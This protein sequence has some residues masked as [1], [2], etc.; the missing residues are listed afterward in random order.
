[1]SSIQLPGTNLI[2]G[3]NVGA[4]GS[5][6]AAAA[7][8]EAFGQVGHAIQAFGEKGAGMLIQAKQS[9][10]R[11]RANDMQ[12]ELSQLMAEQDHEMIENPDATQW[13]PSF[14]KKLE[15][16]RNSYLTAGMSPDEQEVIGGRFNEWAQ[17]ASARVASSAIGAIHQNQT[18][19]VGNLLS[20]AERTGDEDM[21]QNGLS[22]L[23][24]LVPSADFDKVVMESDSR[25]SYF[26]KAKQI[27]EDPLG[28]E[29]KLNSRDFA[30]KNPNLSFEAID[31]LQR[32][33][34]QKA[35]RYRSDFANDVIINGAN[36]TEDELAIMEEAGQIDKTTHARWLVKI[37]S[38][39]GAPQS[40]PAIY[41]ETYARIQSFEP[42]KDPSGRV[43]AGLRSWIASQSLP[44]EELKALNAKLTD[45]VNPATSQQPKSQFESSF[46][47]KTGMDFRRG[48]FG[49][50][51]FPV[52]HDGNPDTPPI[53]PINMGEYDKAWN[54]MG[55]FNEQWR[56][57]LSSMPEDVPFE[58]VNSAYES[59]KKSFK[60]QKP[61]P[62]L[63][64]TAPTPL[65]FDPGATYKSLPGKRSHFGGVPV[66][67]PGVP[68]TGA[69]ATV[70]GGPNDSEDNGKSAF[71]GFT[72]A[73]G[74]EGTA[75]PQALLAAKWPG[76]DKKWLSENVRTVVRS[77]DGV[78][79]SLAL[80]DLGTAEW[81]WERAQRPTLDLTEGAARQLGGRVTYTK[82][83]K[84][85]SVQGLDSI[86]FSVVSIDTG[87]KP[88]E[89]MSWND[90]KKAWFDT[91]RP[92][93]N[94][95]AN[96]GLIALRQHWT[97]AQAN[98]PTTAPEKQ[99]PVL[100]PV[101]AQ[102]RNT[103][104]AAPPKPPAVSPIDNSNGQSAPLSVR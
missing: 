35:N 27:D 18:K 19:S 12:V 60:D 3:Y 10:T 51:R 1:M 99:G 49:K 24:E 11:K 5:P 72:G 22:Q 42:A 70:F 93:T 23:R 4:N 14:E 66:K 79:H 88:L 54:L 50:Y 32:R 15:A 56:G 96:E 65:P 94:E 34:E 101:T 16:A 64:F 73:G 61:M 9:N 91:N 31:D 102:R 40:D 86:N 33:A 95:Q 69:S 57:I 47:Q 21:R 28:S 85:A 44:P 78:A 89:G 84:L 103:P 62:D 29:R 8:W 63:N 46:S 104:P 76:K 30:E 52:D 53:T 17:K 41:E 6:G 97:M 2:Q 26:Q 68:Y 25:V 58:K 77:A 55:N 87:G 92:T 38:Y 59:L 98:A 67:P 48:D 43:E 82:A 81:V 75:I 20:L 37:R 90:A 39:Q 45:R 100:S 74:K 71:G 80:V 7:P 36:P 83:G 13:V